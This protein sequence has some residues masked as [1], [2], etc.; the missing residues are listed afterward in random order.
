MNTRISVSKGGSSLG[1]LALILCA[2]SAAA[3]WF[4]LGANGSAHRLSFRERS[5]VPPMTMANPLAFGKETTLADADT[6]LGAS[7]TLPSASTMSASAVGSVWV[8]QDGGGQGT[9]VAVTLPAVGLILQFIRPVPYPESPAEMYQTEANQQ[10][11]SETVIDLGGVPALAT[12]Q[13]SDQ[14]GQNFGSVEFV[15][16]GT[17]IAVLGHYDVATLRAYATTL[18][19]A[20]SS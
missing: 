3:V 16:K 13:D 14:T 8:R 4:G 9:S 6:K 19:A 18:L 7:V 11:N 15:V 1:A 17:R 10:P 5:L 20:A 2:G 12:R